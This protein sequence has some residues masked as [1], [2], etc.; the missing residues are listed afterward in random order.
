MVHGLIYIYAIAYG[1]CVLLVTMVRSNTIVGIFSSIFR[2][3]FLLFWIK[4]SV[5]YVIS[6]YAFITGVT[7]SFVFYHCIALK[8][9]K[10]PKTLFTCHYKGGPAKETWG[11]SPKAKRSELG[12]D[13]CR[14]S[15]DPLTPGH[16]GECPQEDPKW[17]TDVPSQTG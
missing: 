3:F 1:D 13:R 2:T 7:T 8:K 4:E 6:F 5:S 10:S 17:Q 16:R 9:W 14:P 11:L 12:R 15:Q